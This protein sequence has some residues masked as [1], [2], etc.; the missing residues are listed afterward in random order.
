MTSK[1]A[2]VPLVLRKLELRYPMVTKEMPLG[3]CMVGSVWD[4]VQKVVHALS[5]GDPRT[6]Y[7]SVPYIRLPLFHWCCCCAQRC[8]L[9][10]PVTPSFVS[11][12]P[13][14][15]TIL[16]TLINNLLALFL[17]NFLQLSAFLLRTYADLCRGVCTWT[18]LAPMLYRLKGGTKCAWRVLHPFLEGGKVEIQFAY[19]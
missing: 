15:C 3:F 10:Q 5:A 14:F 6:G 4:S 2:L 19:A 9:L 1:C 11:L 13:Y 16:C 7:L 12:V 17:F 18:L 8:A